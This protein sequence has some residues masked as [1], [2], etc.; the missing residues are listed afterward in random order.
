MTGAELLEVKKSKNISPELFIEEDCL[1]FDA[2][3]RKTIE[4]YTKQTYSKRLN[5]LINERT[6]KLEATNAKLKAEITEFKRMEKELLRSKNELEQRVAERT[7]ELLS[8]KEVA[9]AALHAKSEF[10]AVM[11]HELRTPLNGVIGMANLLAMESLSSEQHECVDIIRSSSESLLAIINDILNF[12]KIE[13]K[14]VALEKKPFNLRANINDIMSLLSFKAKTKGLDIACSID[15]S[16]PE[17]IICDQT[18]LRQVLLN[19]LDNAIKFTDKGRIDVSVSGRNIE[20]GMKEIIFSIKD[21]GIGISDNDILKLFRP[22]SQVDMSNTRKYGG[23]GLGLA[24]SKGLV[25]LMGGEIWVDSEADKGSTFY[26]T[27]VAE[28]LI[29]TSSDSSEPA[30]QTNVLK[31]AI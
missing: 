13:N 11:G 7:A 19:L 20:D 29:D 23:T 18:M 14:I 15:R 5:D 24:V 25:E 26:F 22:F 16:A 4:T 17:I 2:F 31:K 3:H 10:L 1:P 21:T 27:I 6:R 28:E 8:A 9:E 30:L 12:T